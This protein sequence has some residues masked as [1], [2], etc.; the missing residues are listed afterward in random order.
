VV[1]VIS[2]K[3]FFKHVSDIPRALRNLRRLSTSLQK[4]LH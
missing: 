1:G 4:K 2:P 3:C